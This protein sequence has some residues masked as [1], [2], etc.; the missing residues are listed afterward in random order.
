MAVVHRRGPYSAGSM[1]CVSVSEIS[2]NAM[3]SI[4]RHARFLL[5]K[6]HATPQIIVDWFSDQIRASDA[7]IARV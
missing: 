2:A 7:Q 1:R 4:G 6:H 3:F 5:K